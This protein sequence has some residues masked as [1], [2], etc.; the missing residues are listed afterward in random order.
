MQT[1]QEKLEYLNK[2]L[3]TDYKSLDKVDWRMVSKNHKLSEDFIREFQDKVAWTSI[4]RKQKLSESFIREFENKV[5]W[6]YILKHQKVSEDFIREFKY[7]TKHTY[8]NYIDI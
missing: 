1:E 3:G 2:E 4:S 8:L 5:A 6:E 7:L